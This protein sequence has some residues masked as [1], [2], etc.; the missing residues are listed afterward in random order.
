ML[1][2]ASFLTFAT[3]KDGS[4]RVAAVPVCTQEL[5]RIIVCQGTQQLKREKKHYRVY[6]S[7]GFI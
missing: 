5:C 6:S 1:V 7:T 2:L 4:W 3:L